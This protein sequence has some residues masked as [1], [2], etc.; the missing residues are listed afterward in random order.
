MLY[1]SG[2]SD[3]YVYLAVIDQE[4]LAL[5]ELRM[6]PEW[7]ESVQYLA[8]VYRYLA[9]VYR[10]KTL[11]KKWMTPFYQNRFFLGPKGREQ[12]MENWSDLCGSQ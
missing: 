11:D 8:G 4:W 9:G 10:S 6:F 12:K 1:V 3:K 2:I 5:H 7:K